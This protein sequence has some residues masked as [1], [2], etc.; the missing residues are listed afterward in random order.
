MSEIRYIVK[1]KLT[2]TEA[3]QNFKGETAFYYHGKG[4]Y[5]LASWH[6]DG[7]YNHK[8]ARYE[9]LEYG[10][11]REH[12]AKRNWSY[13]NPQNDKHWTTEVEILKIHIK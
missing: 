7:W 12:D 1:S 13:N 9:L 5:V 8:A 10:Y 6:K 3:N 4:D 2:A 11:K